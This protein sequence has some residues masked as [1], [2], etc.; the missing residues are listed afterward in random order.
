MSRPKQYEREIRV[1]LPLDLDAW[2]AEKVRACRLSKSGLIRMLV[3]QERDG[4]E[5]GPRPAGWPAGKPRPAT[6]SRPA[7]LGSGRLGKT[8]SNS[9]EF[10]SDT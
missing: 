7:P 6:G 4:P 8:Y 2:L 3:Q 9:D 1:W 10:L 5:R